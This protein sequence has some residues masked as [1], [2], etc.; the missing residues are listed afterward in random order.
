[1]KNENYKVVLDFLS[2][3]SM[4]SDPDKW[5]DEYK[6]F[7]KETNSKLTFKEFDDILTSLLNYYYK[8]SL[9]YN[10]DTK[11][12]GKFIIRND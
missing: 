5:K 7:K 12:Y 1:M 9:N 3:T 2:T 8:I 11:T 10:P 6:V 4:S